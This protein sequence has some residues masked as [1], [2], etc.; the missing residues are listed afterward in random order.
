[1]RHIGIPAVLVVLM[2]IAASVGTAHAASSVPG[3]MVVRFAPGSDGERRAAVR[4]EHGLRAV[5]DLPLPGLQLVRFAPGRSV[6]AAI[7]ELEREPGVLYAEPNAYYELTATPDDPRFGDQWGLSNTGQTVLGFA[8]TADADIDAP[9]AWNITTG[10]PGV[11]VAVVDSG[12]A[13]DHPDLAPNIWINPGESGAGKETNGLDDD[14]NGFVDDVRGW[15]FLGEDNDPLDSHGHGTGVAGIIG[16]RGDNAR[17]V[18]GVNWQVGLMPVRAGSAYQT[19][20]TTARVLDGFGYAVANGADVVNASFRG[21]LFSQAVLDLIEGAPGVLFVTGSGNQGID[22][23]AT[24]GYPCNFTAANLICVAGTDHD[25]GLAGFSNFG[26]QA[27]DLA[28]PAVRVYTPDIAFG[29]AAFSEGFESDIAATWTTSGANDTWGRTS[30]AAQ[31]GSFSLADSPGGDYANGTSS[32]ARNTS[33][34]SLAGRK[35]C[36]VAMFIRMVTEP[37]HDEL[38]VLGSNDGANG[39]QLDRLSGSI[40]TFTDTGFDMSPFDGDSSV[41]VVLGFVTDADGTFDGVYVD[42]VD[43][44]CLAASYGN[45]VV[46]AFGGTSFA[47]PF[48]SGVAALLWAAEPGLSVAEVKERILSS[49]DPK[50]ALAGKTVTGGRLNAARALTVPAPPAPVDT[51]QT[52]EPSPEPP[53]AEPPLPPVTVAPP[54]PGRDALAPVLRLGGPTSQSVGARRITIVVSCPAEACRA[55]AAGQI[56][57]PGAARAAKRYKLGAARADIAAGRSARLK[58]TI[59][60]SSLRAIKRALRRRRKVSAK[61]TITAVDAAGNAVTKRRTVRLRR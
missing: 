35:G 58:L 59:G 42:D 55:T 15:D 11:T 8:G 7:A 20:F 49:V 17:E 56:T 9:D 5:R 44:R 4:R 46:G 30:P 10:S 23:D 48:V 24:P 22:T 32:L 2:L 29:P 16:A 14:A 34:F 60:R 53:V 1:M 26:A 37:T 52:A 33:P 3:E 47:S 28:A 27:V 13:Y 6:A 12:V 41:Y 54:P 57:I 45:D 43:V 39:I 31:T 21:P 19:D 18:T 51:E 40:P 61:V 25:D 50:P 38:V 36:S